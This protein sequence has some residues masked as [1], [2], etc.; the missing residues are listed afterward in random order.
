MTLLVNAYPIHG[1]NDK[2]NE[3]IWNT[4]TPHEPP[5][6]LSH[7]KWSLKTPDVP[8][9]HDN[10]QAQQ[11]NHMF[12]CLPLLVWLAGASCC[13]HCWGLVQLVSPNIGDGHAE[14]DSFMVAPTH[15]ATHGISSRQV[16][17]GKEVGKSDTP[18]RLPK[19]TFFAT[20]P[21]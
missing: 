8:V 4:I 13:C 16:Q 5:V 15:S 1:K 3:N 14:S 18:P 19:W 11:G 21:E 2:T 7:E 10:S 17:N 6:S 20:A 12:V 9:C